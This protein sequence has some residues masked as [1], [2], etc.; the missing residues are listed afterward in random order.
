VRFLG[1]SF[2]DHEDR[3][4]RADPVF[5]IIDLRVLDDRFHAP[6]IRGGQGATGCQIRV[7]G[8]EMPLVLGAAEA[9]EDVAGMV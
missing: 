7:G 4:E 2:G 6:V 8:G 1:H 3:V 9:G 5:F